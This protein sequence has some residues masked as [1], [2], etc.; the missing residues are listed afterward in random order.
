MST[1]TVFVIPAAAARA[2]EKKA[3]RDREEAKK[4]QAAFDAVKDLPFE[5]RK[6]G[7]AALVENPRAKDLFLDMVDGHK[8][9]GR[10][11]YFLKAPADEEDMVVYFAEAFNMAFLFLSGDYIHPKKC[12][13]S[14]RGAGDR[15]VG[16]HLKIA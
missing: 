2:L 6:A 11:E 12:S 16:F 5:E 10:E 14:I 4:R 1:K 13:L 9:H 7:F 3:E 15:E 8:N